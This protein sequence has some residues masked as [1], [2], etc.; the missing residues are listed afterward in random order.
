MKK[1]RCV[2]EVWITFSASMRGNV[3]KPSI[4]FIDSDLCSVGFALQQFRHFDC[5]GDYP[6]KI[7]SRQ[8]D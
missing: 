8:I 5:R 4:Y 7:F 2:F 6:V 3:P 1:M